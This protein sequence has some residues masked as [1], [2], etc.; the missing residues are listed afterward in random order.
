MVTE[1]FITIG[2]VDSNWAANKYQFEVRGEQAHT[3][4]TVIADRR[5]ARLAAG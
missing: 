5:D 3:G 2:V 1:E 4:S